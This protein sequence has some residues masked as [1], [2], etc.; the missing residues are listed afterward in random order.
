MKIAR[1]P[2]REAERI[3]R[4]HDLGILDTL[5][6][7]AF[8]AITELAARVCETPIALISFIDVKRQWFKSRLGLPAT[9]TPRDFSFC[10]HTILTPD[11]V[12]EVEDALCDE[13]FRDNP[14]VTGEP[15]IRYYAG[16]SILTTD[17]LA[18]GTVCVVDQRVR[19]LSALQLD[20]LRLLASAVTR[21]LEH[22]TTLHDNLSNEAQQL[23]HRQ[24]VM[25]AMG[26]ASLDL[27]VFIDR[28]YRYRYA[29]GSYLAYWKLNEDQLLRMTVPELQTPE[30]FAATLQPHLDA[31]LRGE[32][33]RF[34][35]V[36]DFTA[37]GPRHVEVTY[38]PALFDEHGV[39]TGVVGRVQDIHETKARQV[40]LEDTV[41]LLEQ[42]TLQQQQY[43]HVLSHDLKEPLNTIGNFTSLID[44]GYRSTM[45]ATGRNYLDHVI[46]G[47]R[48]MRSLID[49]LRRFFEVENHVV[50]MEAV[51]L[52]PIVRQALQELAELVARQRATVRIDPLPVVHGNASLLRIC[53]QNL[54]SNAL[55]FTRPG[56]PPQVH[57][58]GTASEAGVSVHVDDQGMGIDTAHHETIFAPYARLHA[59]RVSEGA[60]LGLPICR[61]IARMHGGD[62]VVQSS[63]GVGSRF[64]LVLPQHGG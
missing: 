51:A 1:Q 63:S 60:G 46:T 37:T 36:I 14:M 38:I 5:P 15:H 49:D 13:R 40:Q 6:N 11:R 47:T 53:L 59:R 21:L 26:N 57:V 9:E 23:R 61:R 22:S 62:I 17:G 32:Q 24:A 30:A 54:L 31:A 56:E 35:T 41:K 44:E 16:A 52:E 50:S 58:H 42:R 64:S 4:L 45:D 39:P 28:D 27:K 33:R 20:M 10:A 48:R 12:T 19:R 55:R 3:A 18:L 43:I 7:P 2:T 25:L 8:D 34:Q 29:N